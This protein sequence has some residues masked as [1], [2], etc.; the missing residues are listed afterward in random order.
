MSRKNYR[1]GRTLCEHGLNIV[2]MRLII[3]K[4]SFNREMTRPNM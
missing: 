3:A 1:N 4:T 2:R